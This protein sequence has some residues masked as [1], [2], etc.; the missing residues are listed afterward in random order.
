MPQRWRKENTQSGAE[1]KPHR[2]IRNL[3]QNA[4]HRD[5]GDGPTLSQRPRRSKSDRLVESPH[6]ATR[7]PRRILGRASSWGARSRTPSC[8]LY[9]GCCGGGAH[10]SGLA[11]RHHLRESGRSHGPG[12]PRCAPHRPGQ[13]RP[14]RLSGKRALGGRLLQPGRRRGRRQS[15]GKR[16]PEPRQR[17]PRGP[18]RPPQQ[19]RVALLVEGEGTVTRRTPGDALPDGRVLT[20]VAANTATLAATAADTASEAPS[21]EP[22]EAEDVLVLFPP[23]NTAPLEPASSPD[24]TEPAPAA[25]ASR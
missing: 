21:E 3:A 18:R 17:G 9:M 19:P 2:T 7:H 16:R 11:H 15:G 8:H 20:E 24:T 5:L 12:G 22:S 10:R 25:N 14:H 1:P 23:V 4:A 13:R 6:A